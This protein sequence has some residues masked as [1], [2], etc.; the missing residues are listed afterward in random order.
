MRSFNRELLLKSAWGMRK[1]LELEQQTYV[2]IWCTC[3]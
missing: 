3:V 2:G 1:I